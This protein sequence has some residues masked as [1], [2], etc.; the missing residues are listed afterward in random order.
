MPLPLTETIPRSRRTTENNASTPRRE[1][2]LVQSALRTRV[3]GARAFQIPSNSNQERMKSATVAANQGRRSGPKDGNPTHNQSRT[4]D[5]SHS[6]AQT[7]AQDEIT[8]G[9]VPLVPEVFSVHVI[10]STGEIIRRQVGHGVL[11]GATPDIRNGASATCP[12]HQIKACSVLS[13]AIA[14]QQHI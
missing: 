14:A 6:I 13:L 8:S 2:R 4:P 12:M 10:Q 5:T 9:S 3:P 7:Q 1:R 11:R